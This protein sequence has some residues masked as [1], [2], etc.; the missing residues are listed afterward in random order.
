[1]IFQLA[2]LLT[3]IFASPTIAQVPTYSDIDLVIF[4]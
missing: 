1:M 2:L 4:S 3:I